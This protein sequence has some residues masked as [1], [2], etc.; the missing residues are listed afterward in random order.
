MHFGCCPKFLHPSVKRFR[1]FIASLLAGRIARF[2]QP[3][4]YI[5]SPAGERD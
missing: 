4:K 5:F 3:Q 2:F 1:S